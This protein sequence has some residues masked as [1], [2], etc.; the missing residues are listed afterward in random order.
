[1]SLATVKKYQALKKEQK[2]KRKKRKAKKRV[3]LTKYKDKPIEFAQEILGV[4]HLT[5]EQKQI[6]L[7]VRDR[8]TTNVQAAHS[9]GKSY[10]MSLVVIWYVFAVQGLVYTTAPTLQQV[11]DILWSE[12]RQLYDRYNAKLGGS[13]GELFLKKNEF[14]KAI[15]YTAKHTDSNAFQGR[16]AI[17][18]LLIQDEADG[19]SSVIDEA[20]ESCL[21]GSQNR[22]V[23]IGNP[24]TSNSS[25]FKACQLDNIKITVWNHPNVKFGYELVEADNGKPIHR[26]KPEIADRILKPLNEQK[27]DPVKPQEEWPEDLP[28]D[29]IP[30]A[31]S[32]SWIEKVRV[33]YG[34]FSAYWMSRVEAEFPGDDV[35]G[36]IP[37]SWLRNARERY[38]NDPDYWDKAAKND[39]WRIGADVADG[40]GDEHAVSTWRGKV[41]YGI[42]YIQPRNDEQDTVRLA[43]DYLIPMI[44]NFGGMY[45]IAVDNTGVGAGTLATLK[46]RGYFA[47]GC[48]FGADAKNKLEYANLKTELF[49]EMRDGLRLGQIAIAPLGDDEDRVFEE[50]ASIRYVTNT[51]DK[52][53]TEKK[54]DTKKRLKRSPDGADA[55]AIAWMIKP[56]DLEN[57]NTIPA[58]KPKTQGEKLRELV[59]SSEDWVDDIST[60]EA[61][62]Y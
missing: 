44:E 55:S 59:L 7:S 46:Q 51:E 62:R 50:I 20:F 23:R 57:K 25:F 61:N 45:S 43:T 34:E 15:G 8:N 6:L 30:G 21:T 14:S 56:L 52:K 22:G 1:M 3:D 33:K 49:W 10:S 29:I 24:L 26:L 41:W 37:M 12:I 36:L 47:T 32:V 19:I 2:E 17:N 60:E 31:V 58:D 40:G 27:D 54:A 13:R 4:K 28:R 9:V 42:K 11:K 48:K 53:R 38:D 16:H 39:R 5:E 18:L 35:D